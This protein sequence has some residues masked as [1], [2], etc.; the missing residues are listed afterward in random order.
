[1]NAYE[2][3]IKHYRL[4]SSG[5]ETFTTIL[6]P[7]L[8]NDPEFGIHLLRYVQRAFLNNEL[9]RREY[10]RLFNTVQELT[11]N[12][13]LTEQT[14]TGEINTD[15]LPGQDRMAVFKPSDKPEN[16][17]TE[18]QKLKP[19]NQFES[20]RLEQ[21]SHTLISTN[22]A[23]TESIDTSLETQIE[24]RV[25]D[26]ELNTTASLPD[27]ASGS[28]KPSVSAGQILKQRFRFVEPIGKGGMGVVYKAHD[29]VRAQARDR[30]PYVAIKVLS[31]KFKTHS[32]A[33]IAL[34]R[35]ASKTQRLAHPNIATVYDFDHDDNVVF[36]T[37]ELLDGSPANK[38]LHYVHKSDLQEQPRSTA[39]GLPQA[40]NLIEQLC[41]GLAYAHQ[42]GLVHSDLK[43]ANIFITQTGT[44]KLLDFGI[45]RAVH[46]DAELSDTV[47]DPASLKAL[48]PAYATEEM[49]NFEPADPRDDVYGLACITYEFLSG[50]HPFN[51]IT[52]KKAR[53]MKLEVAPIRGLTRRQQKALRQG[54]Q[55]ER[56]K[57]TE[58]VEQFWQGLQPYQSKAWWLGGAAAVL[59]MSTGILLWP[60]LQTQW[61]L[62]SQLQLVERIQNGNRR[63]LVTLLEALPELPSDQQSALTSVLREDIIRYYIDVVNT[64]INVNQQQY[65]FP[66]AAER[67]ADAQRLYPDSALL[68]D[69]S[70]QF[71]DNRQRFI[72][73]LLANYERVSQ[74]N[75]DTSRILE[76]LSIADPSHPLLTQD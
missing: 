25:I 20:D 24:T 47:F 37:M 31:E 44:V 14:I 13:T 50:V 62:E 67:L 39:D 34:Q 61:Q 42:Q 3:L 76:I 52:A 17:Q 9:S 56:A 74:G 75:G 4:H 54:L 65:N 10:R 51:R 53:Q 27:L 23:K 57:R 15:S 58:S 35:E 43:P 59:L 68:G 2:T 71:Q 12:I 73:T 48:T 18:T 49:L 38:V 26:L 28:S 41:A 69:L 11:L 63:E 1:M 16:V 66:L 32:A 30:H 22:Q 60:F 21:S 8:E 72:D 70:R 7:L 64:A 40:L 46:N 45:T 29:Q 36:M 55:F 6:T 33:F 19:A 5:L